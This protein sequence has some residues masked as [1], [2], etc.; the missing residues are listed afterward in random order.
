MVLL[1]L[2]LPTSDRVST[3]TPLHGLYDFSYDFYEQAEFL[4]LSVPVSVSTIYLL[5]SNVFSCWGVSHVGAF[6]LSRRIIYL[7]NDG[8]CF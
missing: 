5:P 6:A 2:A 7:V 3:R 8:L 4:Q 1:L